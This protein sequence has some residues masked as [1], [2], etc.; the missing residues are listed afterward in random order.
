VATATDEP[1]KY[2]PPFRQRA[3]R[4][5]HDFTLR[6]R[7]RTIMELSREDGEGKDA[8]ERLLDQLQDEF[9]GNHA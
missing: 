8:Y 4:L 2:D 9:K 6:A 7:G 1:K 5:L 3:R